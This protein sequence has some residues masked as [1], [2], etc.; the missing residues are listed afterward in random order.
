MEYFLHRE[1]D[2]LNAHHDNIEEL[3]LANEDITRITLGP[4]DQA[5]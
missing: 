4:H 5:V 3:E 1:L 2:E